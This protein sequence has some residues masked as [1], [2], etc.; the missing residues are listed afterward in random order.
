MKGEGRSTNSETPASDQLKL[1]AERIRAACADAALDGFEEARIGGLCH[2]GA[3]E[4][5]ISAIR[6]VDVEALLQAPATGASDDRE[7]QT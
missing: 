1:L 4:N 5:A 2:D 3:I 7:Q 6:M